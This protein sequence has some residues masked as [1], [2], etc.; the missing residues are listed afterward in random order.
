MDKPLTLSAEEKHWLDTAS[1]AD[2]LA[3]QRF[4]RPGEVWFCGSNGEY[5]EQ[6]IRERRQELLPFEADEI[7]RRIGSHFGN[8]WKNLDAG[9]EGGEL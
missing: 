3:R 5:Y 6:K 4:A 1:Y 7:E 2:L 8:F 9:K